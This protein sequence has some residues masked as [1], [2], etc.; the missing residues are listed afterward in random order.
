MAQLKHAPA[1]V[2]LKPVPNGKKLKEEK[3]SVLPILGVIKL[4]LWEIITV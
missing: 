1:N 4:V 2:L 3:V